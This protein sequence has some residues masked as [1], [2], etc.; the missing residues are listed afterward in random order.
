M[1]RLKFSKLK[2]QDRGVRHSHRTAAMAARPPAAP[3][4]HF[5]LDEDDCD[6]ADEGR[7]VR[8]RRS[9]AGIQRVT[10]ANASD[11]QCGH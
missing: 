3:V 9:F 11:A 5:E 10:N 2:S 8:T 7:L 6:D 4:S 1:K